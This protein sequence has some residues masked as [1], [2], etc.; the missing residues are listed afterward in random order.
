MATY[1]FDKAVQRY[2]GPNG[3]FI[4]DATVR[5]LTQEAIRLVQDDI[6]TMADLLIQQKLSLAEWQ[7]GTALALK[8]MHTQS[9]LLGRGGLKMMQQSDYDLLGDMLKQQYRYLDNF[10]QALKDGRISVA[11]FRARLQLYLNA[12]RGTYEQAKRVGHTEAAFSYEQRFLSPVQ[13]CRPCIDYAEV[14]RVPINTLP[15][16]GTRCDCTVNCQCHFQYYHEAGDMLK[17][18]FGWIQGRS[19]SFLNGQTV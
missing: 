15:A 14:G 1:T 6:N 3:R 13:N 18:S 2:R 4:S 16:I 8:Q 10:A 19:F 12:A 7:R 17:A 5:K 9:Y 11:Q